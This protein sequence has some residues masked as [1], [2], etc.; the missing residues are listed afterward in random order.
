MQL[1]YI[2]GHGRNNLF[3][4]VGSQAT[5]GGSID[6]GQFEVQQFSRFTGL[7]RPDSVGATG[8]TFRWRMGI[9]S[10]AFQVSS[11]VTVGS[12]GAAFDQIN[13]GRYTDFSF[14]AIDS[15]TTYGIV[16]M[17]EPLR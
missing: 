16:I 7:I 14:T 11:S 4:R 5:Q 6:F 15:T 17:G 3:S 13:F 8:L 12:G 2:G 9:N 10:G 1:G